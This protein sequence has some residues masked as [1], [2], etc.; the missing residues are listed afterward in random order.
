MKKYFPPEVEDLIASLREIPGDKSPT[1]DLGTKS[2]G[3]VISAFVEKYHIGKS[4]PEEAILENWERIVGPSFAN[5]CRP[6]KI[7]AS[8]CLLVQVPNPT[9]RR[10]LIFMEDRIL[11]ALGSIEGCQ[12]IHH[13][14][15]KSGT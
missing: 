10:E 4:T 6:E 9:L 1:R 11:T 13:V 12:H 8:G 15:F 2:W 3:S 7:T 14:I 5:R